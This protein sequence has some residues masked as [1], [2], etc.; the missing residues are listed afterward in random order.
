MMMWTWI[1]EMARLR[2]EDLRR[3]A[4]AEARARGGRGNRRPDSLRLW[5]RSPG[6]RLDRTGERVRAGE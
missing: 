5:R 1:R 6:S 2:A 3:E 4:E